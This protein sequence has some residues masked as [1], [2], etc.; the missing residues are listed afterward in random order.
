LC[1]RNSIN[2]NEFMGKKAIKL[3]RNWAI[4]LKHLFFKSILINQ[5]YFHKQNQF[6]TKCLLNCKNTHSELERTIPHKCCW[7]KRNR[8]QW[9]I[10]QKM[11]FV[12]E[13]SYE[14]CHNCHA[15]NHWSLWNISSFRWINTVRRERKSFQKLNNRSQPKNK[16]TLISK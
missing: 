10:N 8:L 2:C 16:C 5:C 7:M 4:W 6:A 9:K 1:K 14:V 11:E 3:L 12:E 13:N 15:L